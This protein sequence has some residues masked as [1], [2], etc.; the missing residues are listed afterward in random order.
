MT[1]GPVIASARLP[2]HEVIGAKYLPERTGSNRVHGPRLQIHQHGAWDVPSAAGLVVINI[3]AFEL[4]IGVSAVLPRVVNS[5][6]VA[7]DLPE[8]GSDLVAALASLNVKNLT[9]LVERVRARSRVLQ[10]GLFVFL[11]ESEVSDRKEMTSVE[12]GERGE[13]VFMVGR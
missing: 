1:L 8:L 4:E 12:R 11:F 13:A 10:F 5:V 7:D 3:D 6:L 2:E 9:H